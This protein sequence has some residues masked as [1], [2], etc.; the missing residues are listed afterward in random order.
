MGKRIIILTALLALCVDVVPAQNV[1]CLGLKNPTNFTLTGGVGRT[2]WTGYIGKKV[3][4]AS[5]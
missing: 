2:K 3:C 5:S 4:T 1:N